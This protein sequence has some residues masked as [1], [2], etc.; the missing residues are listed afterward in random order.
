VE[1]GSAFVQAPIP[2]AAA[3]Q[4]IAHPHQVIDRCGEGEEPADSWHGPMFHVTEQPHG[5]HPAK[6]LFD[7]FA[8]LLTDRVTSVS[9]GPTVNRTG[10]VRRVLG[11]MGRDL[12]GPQI[13]HERLGVVILIAPRVMIA[14][15]TDWR[16]GRRGWAAG[17]RVSGERSL[18][19]P[20]GWV[21]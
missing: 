21:S 12:P 18:N 14:E 10:P 13:L 8:V 9:R 5:L 15:S 20:A 2:H 1:R 6:D 19:S 4:E 3:P 7:A 16:M 17:T 11:H